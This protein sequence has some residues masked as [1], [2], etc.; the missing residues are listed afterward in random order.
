MS[1]GEK[2]NKNLAKNRLSVFKIRWN[3]KLTNQLQSFCPIESLENIDQKLFWNPQDKQFIKNKVNSYSLQ[4]FRDLPH[5]RK[6]LSE[7]I[8]KRWS[9]EIIKNP[10]EK[11]FKDP[12]SADRPLYNHILLDPPV[13]L[14]KPIRF[15]TKIRTKPEKRK[16]VTSGTLF[17]KRISSE[18]ERLSII[19]SIN[20]KELMTSFLKRKAEKESL[21]GAK[22]EKGK[23]SGDSS[24]L[25]FSSELD[26]PKNKK[27]RMEDLEKYTSF[28]GISSELDSPKNKK[29]RMEDLD[30]HPFNLDEKQLS[31]FE[32]KKVESF[33]NSSV[34]NINP[35]QKSR[36]QIYYPKEEGN[37]PD[38]R[39]AKPP[40]PVKKQEINKEEK[41]NQLFDYGFECMGGSKIY[42][43]EGNCE[44]VVQKI[45]QRTKSL[46]PRKLGM[47]SPLVSGGLRSKLRNNFGFKMNLKNN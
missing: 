13:K 12:E 46:S 42:F 5:R 9:V 14:S 22:E 28:L 17:N 25:G 47:R 43:L 34:K 30:K 19:K 36:I 45:N 27:K 23:T 6:Y 33:C 41:Y 31:D 29:K 32:I 44:N 40:S 4:S 11:A 3:F 1:S 18:M 16:N 35:K 26:S 24:F 8:H 20:E 15:E 7:S 2:F 38:L 21:F 37:G 39:P 10:I